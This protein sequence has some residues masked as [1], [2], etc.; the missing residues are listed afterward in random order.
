MDAAS[1]S[2]AAGGA[3]TMTNRVVKPVAWIQV[4]PYRQRWGCQ[5]PLQRDSWD[6]SEGR[7]PYD[8]DR[9]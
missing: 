9:R 1:E 3:E 8:L 7:V 2:R 6:G 4:G 5:L